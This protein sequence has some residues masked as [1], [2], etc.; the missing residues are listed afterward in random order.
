M[1]HPFRA[2]ALTGAALA[3]TL[4]L[5]ACGSDDKAA[6]A[7]SDSSS[8]SEVSGLPVTLTHKYG[9]TTI[10][11]EPKRVVALGYTDQDPVLQTG[12]V[13]LG[14]G[15]FLGGFDWRKRAWAQD[16]LNGAEPK[17]VSGQQ[18]NFEAVA[19]QRP[20]VIFA[21]T[22][23]LKKAD[24]DKLSKIAPTV[25]QDGDYVDFGMPWDETQEIVGKALGRKAAADEAIAALKAKFAEVKQAHP[26][27]EGKTAIMAYGGPDG[28]GAYSSQDTRS[29]FLGDLGF[30]VPAEIDKLAKG[31]FF[32]SFSEE[33]F[34]LLDQDVVFMYGDEK[35]IAKNKIVSRLDAVKEGRVIYIPIP[36]EFAGALG[37]S[38]TLSETFLLDNYVDTIAAA[39]DGDPAT[40][41]EQPAV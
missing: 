9:S 30:K 33:Q 4:T 39:V 35:D 41:V 11:S 25:A 2:L 15:D 28:Y 34:R 10:E 18:I 17:V 14:V 29:R 3:A 40:K 32:T 36:S 19:A 8:A 23:G 21:L 26:E 7:S 27:F 22:A 5:A 31:S 13:P 12:V 6:S 37:F 1:P 16:L 24:Y 38:S 20:D